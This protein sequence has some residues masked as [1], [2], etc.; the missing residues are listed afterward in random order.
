MHRDLLGKNKQLYA[1]NIICSQI[2]KG[3]LLKSGEIIR[4]PFRKRQASVIH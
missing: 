3:S 1:P 2:Y 4:N